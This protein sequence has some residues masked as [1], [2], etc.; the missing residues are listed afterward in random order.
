EPLIT[1]VG[2]DQ[3]SSNPL[4]R[5]F[6]H[7]SY[8]DISIFLRTSVSAFQ[9]KHVY[10][11]FCSFN[12]FAT[13]IA[14]VILICCLAVEFISDCNLSNLSDRRKHDIPYSLLICVSIAGSR[15]VHGPAYSNLPAFSPYQLTIFFHPR[16]SLADNRPPKNLPSFS[17]SPSKTSN[18]EAET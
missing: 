12:T 16:S 7:R 15:L 2:G 17:P 8:P 9:V 1:S 13:R 6:F 10:R 4:I 18:V 14:V 3:P 5:V 11:Y